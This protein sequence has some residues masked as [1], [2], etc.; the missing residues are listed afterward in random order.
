MKFLFIF[1]GCMAIPLLGS[2]HQQDVMREFLRKRELTRL[3]LVER[4]TDIERQ[5]NRIQA[6]VTQSDCSAQLL[7]VNT[8]LH[9]DR[10]VLSQALNDLTLNGV[11]ISPK[12]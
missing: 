3:M 9:N 1:V 10:E 5:I 6:D 8:V 12:R 11:P 2:H 7:L 4:L